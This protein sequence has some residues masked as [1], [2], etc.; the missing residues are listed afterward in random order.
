MT[1]EGFNQEF[2]RKS[3]DVARYSA[4]E[5]YSGAAV[6]Y[7][8]TPTGK[9]DILLH[10]LILTI[11]DSDSDYN[12]YGNLTALTNGFSL[13]VEDADG[14]LVQSLLGGVAIK[15][16]T[17]LARVAEAVEPLN[18]G[19][20]NTRLTRVEI[21]FEKPV[22]IRAR[23]SHQLAWILNDDF[24]GLDDHTLLAEFTMKRF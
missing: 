21:E 16:V 18:D 24:S 14:T 1:V 12:K 22:V 20:G 13:V 9:Q 4:T 19:S 15:Q 8:L 11:S 23:D 17:H 2:L 3:T 7:T 5:D 6:R 10:K